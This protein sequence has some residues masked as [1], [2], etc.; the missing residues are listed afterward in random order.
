MIKI[1]SIGRET[2]DIFS[3]KNVKLS[4]ELQRVYITDIEN[5][6]VDSHYQICIQDWTKAKYSTT[7]VTLLIKE[8]IEIKSIIDKLIYDITMDEIHRTHEKMKQKEEYEESISG[9]KEN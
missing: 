8:A 4:F 5:H 7:L 3:S 1:T 2:I 6:M 9:K